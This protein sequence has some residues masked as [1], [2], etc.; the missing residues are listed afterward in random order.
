MK[1]LFF[2]PK[3]YFIQSGRY[4]EVRRKQE[5]KREHKCQCFRI[6]R[7]M[8][9]AFEKHVVLT[10]PMYFNVEIWIEFCVIGM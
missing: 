8:T 4:F 5:I 3:F 6:F 10:V 9:D 1:Y 2:R 7:M